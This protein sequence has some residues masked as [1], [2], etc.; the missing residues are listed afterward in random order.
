MSFITEEQWAQYDRDGFLRL[1]A[2][3]DKEELQALQ[4]RIDDIMMG[5]AEL[6]YS[7]ILM[8]LDSADGKYENAGVQSSGHKGATLN[9]RKIQDLEHDSLFMECMRKPMFR[10][11]CARVYGPEIPIAAYRA[12]FMNKPANAGTLLPWHQDRWSN[13]DRDPLITTWLALDPATIENGC[14]EVV[15]GS[16]KWGLLN[17]D[18]P[19]GFVTPEQGEKAMIENG[20]EFLEMAPGEVVLLHNWLL[21]RSDKNH[22]AQSRR[23]FSVCYM[24][25]RT[26]ASSGEQFTRIFEPSTAELVA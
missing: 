6:D 19:S 5:R 8:Q 18:H 9:Y 15:V 24:D 4:N 16:H 12:M 13:L 22:S 10:E 26:V 7:R 21:H 11:I 3:L 20:T 17:P 1:G 14:V 2:V 23:A 25:G